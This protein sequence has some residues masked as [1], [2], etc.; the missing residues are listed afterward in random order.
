MWLYHS[1]NYEPRDTDAGLIGAIVITRKG[2]AREDGTPKDVDREFVTAYFLIRRNNSWC[3][4][5]NINT[6]AVD[7]KN[8]NKLESRPVDVDGNFSIVG[9]G[10]TAANFRL[11]ING[12]LY[13]NVPVMDDA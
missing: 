5:H 11:T 9:S 12:Y 2:M 3:L 10:F 4:D 7:P 13:G 8:V 1:Q 6:F